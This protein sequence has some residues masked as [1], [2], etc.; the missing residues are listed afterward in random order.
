MI[1]VY[2]MESNKV[3]KF[4]VLLTA[5]LVLSC[6]IMKNGKT[7]M[8]AHNEVKIIELDSIDTEDEDYTRETSEQFFVPN[9]D[10]YVYYEDGNIIRTLYERKYTE[11]YPD[12]HSFKTAVLNNNVNPPL[13]KGMSRDGFIFDTDERFLVDSVV[14]S[15][16]DMLSIEKF[17]EKY[18]HADGNNRLKFN[19]NYPDTQ[20]TVAYCLWLTGKYYFYRGGFAGGFYVYKDSTLNALY[21]M[22]N[23]KVLE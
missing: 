13:P 19:D 14:M 3:K 5:I 20:C 7:L 4:I 8:N 16:F 21:N 1:S 23:K 10:G 17:V 12:Y 11:F 18:C 2:N 22:R 9:Q 6:S 15:D